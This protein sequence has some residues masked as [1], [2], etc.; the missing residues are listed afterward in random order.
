ML[1]CYICCITSFAVEYLSNP[2]ANSIFY[3]SWAVLGLYCDAVPYTLR[4]V[5]HTKL[6]SPPKK[7][8]NVNCFPRYGG[9][10]NNF[11][12]LTL[13]CYLHQQYPNHS[14]ILGTASD[15]G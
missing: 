3:G 8:N 10:L 12:K 14:S 6:P 2:V 4:A 15:C 9:S 5:E 13:I 7:K 1:L 11:A